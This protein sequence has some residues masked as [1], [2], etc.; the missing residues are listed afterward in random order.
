[1][2]SLLIGAASAVAFAPAAIAGPYINIENNAGFSGA[3]D[4]GGLD[5][6]RSRLMLAWTSL[7]NLGE[8]WVEV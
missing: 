4:E 2:K 7:M 1:M 5:L 6:V 3:G 8:R